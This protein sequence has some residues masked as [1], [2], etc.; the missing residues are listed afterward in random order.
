LGILSLVPLISVT[1]SAPGTTGTIE[2]S[3]NQ[4]FKDTT[5]TIHLEGLTGDRD[6][7]IT[8]TTGCA[9]NFNI[10][11]ATD[12]DSKDYTL[13]LSSPSSGEVCTISLVGFGT[14]GNETNVVDSIDVRI[15][16]GQ[17]LIPS[18]FILSVMAPL[19]ILIIVAALVGNFVRGTR[20]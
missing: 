1:Q 8:F 7:G 19:L 11:T 15:R 16:D 12:E 13:K 14:Y 3:A 18:D 17:D 4:V 9:S 10:T 2:V 20:Q 5:A 6:Y